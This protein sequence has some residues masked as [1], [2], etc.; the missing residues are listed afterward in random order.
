[1]MREFPSHRNILAEFSDIFTKIFEET[2][3]TPVQIAANDFDAE[4]IKSALNF[5]YDK[6]NAII[7]KEMEVFKFAI[8]FGIQHLI[9][10][11]VSFFEQSVNP[12]NVCEFIQIAYSH[13]FEH[14]K[15]KCL[16]ILAEKKEEMELTKIA[17]LPQNIFV[18]FYFFK[19]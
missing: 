7:G 17:K 13:N 8:N 6:S 9:D 3:E 4:T 11:C 1:M 2:L 14:L 12:T 5:L 19:L 16:R 10:A 15:Q 18:D